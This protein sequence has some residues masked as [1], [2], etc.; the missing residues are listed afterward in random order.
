M[1]TIDNILEDPELIKRLDLIERTNSGSPNA[2]ASRQSAVEFC[3]MMWRLAEQEGTNPFKE[4]K[5]LEELLSD[6]D[7][8][9]IFDKI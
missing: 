4:M 2:Y 9:K 6:K 8:E 7:I 3:R 5:L 1:K